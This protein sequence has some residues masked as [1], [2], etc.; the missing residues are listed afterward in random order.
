[1]SFFPGPTGRQEELVISC[2]ISGEPGAEE[3]SDCGMKEEIVFKGTRNGVLMLLNDELDYPT[4]KRKLAERLGAAENFFYRGA[5]VTIDVGNR[6][7]TSGQL[8][9]LE[10]MLRGKHGLELLNVVHGPGDMED[11]E[12]SRPGPSPETDHRGERAWWAGGSDQRELAARAWNAAQKS[13]QSVA[14]AAPA[15]PPRPKAED[16][17]AEDLGAGR[18]SLLVKRTLR[19]GQ[20]V[21]FG[22]NLVILGDVNPGAEVIATGD[23]VVMG[24]LRGVAH[25][26]APYGGST[27]N[28]G[29]LV[30]AFRL[31]PTQLRIAN[32]ISRPPE[33]EALPP[34]GP[35]VAYI[36][37]GTVV[38]DEY[39]PHGSTNAD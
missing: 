33:D 11:A 3:T 38:I 18:N 6:I 28:P 22:G 14:A 9:E 36:R 5:Q 30:V 26:G 32:V 10:E 1:M 4:L 16:W 17:R 2:R 15:A 12:A 13:L 8:I 29:A 19:S 20:R 7:L 31:Q 34:T 37:D 24:V 21:H 27:G 35:E 23:I 39:P 25:A